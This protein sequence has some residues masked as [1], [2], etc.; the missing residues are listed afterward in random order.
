MPSFQ[1]ECVILDMHMPVVT[2]IDVL[3]HL[4]D[5]RPALPVV[6]LTACSGVYLR[7]EANTPAVVAFFRKPLYEDL[8]VFMNTLRGILRLDDPAG[9]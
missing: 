2:G 1:P 6:F 8:A 7:Q 3:E 4:T 5:T 9:A